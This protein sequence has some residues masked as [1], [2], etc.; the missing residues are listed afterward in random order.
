MKRRFCPCLPMSLSILLISV[1]LLVSC[2]RQ[3]SPV[4][5]YGWFAGEA[6]L[7]VSSSDGKSLVTVSLPAD[8]VAGY[9]NYLTE[10]GREATLQQAMVELCGI[11][12]AGYFG[13][14]ETDL[15]RIRDLLDSLAIETGISL[16][17]SPTAT[18]RIQALVS[19]AKPLRKTAMVDTLGTLSGISAAD[20]L[21]EELERVT[22]CAGY[23]VNEFISIDD[24]TDWQVIGPWLSLWIRQALAAVQR[25]R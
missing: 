23:S 21:F 24:T 8:V 15:A 17:A 12:A 9:W 25:S 19:Y 20:G 22:S 5:R 10:S 11:P 6:V 14:T 1:P 16:T 7:L 2:F 4:C 3:S 13:G 18:Q